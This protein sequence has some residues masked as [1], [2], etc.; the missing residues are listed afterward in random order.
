MVMEFFILLNHGG[1]LFT[2]GLLYS[3]FE[4]EFGKSKFETSV[5]SALYSSSVFIFAP[6][7][8][9]LCRRF[10]HRKTMISG[11]IISAVALFVSA[12][13]PSLYMLY[14]TAGLV[15]GCGMSMLVV[16][17]PVVVGYYFTKWRQVA[18]GILF[19]G[20]G[21]GLIVYT[22]TITYILD[23]YGWR[24]TLIISSGL[25]LNGAVFA[26]FFRPLPIEEE[27][28]K[29][30]N[31]IDIAIFK[32]VPF[33]VLLLTILFSFFAMSIPWIIVPV[34]AK[35][36]EMTGTEILIILTA[37]GICGILGRVVFTLFGLLKNFN[38]NLGMSIITL[39]NGVPILIMVYSC[40]FWA[41]AVLSS[42]LGFCNGYTFPA[43]SI[44]TVDLVGVQKFNSAWGLVVC[45]MGIA[46]LI[47]PPLAG[48]IYDN[49]ENYF[50]AALLT[51]IV[52]TLAAS[53]Y[54][55]LDVYERRFKKK[56]S[57]EKQLERLD[58]TD[59]IGSKIYKSTFS[60]GSSVF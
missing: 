7:T 33:L 13:A 56:E 46:W 42:I 50:G 5:V 57:T 3:Y 21:V 35:N 2:P 6:F 8:S 37:V 25:V 54:I 10:G 15:A 32:D 53:F 31:A 52:S 36:C 39:I 48:L 49:T 40:N 24:G 38:H 27:L 9:M 20:S 43:S 47:G 28:R 4:K 18:T 1:L 34:Q 23:Y 26:A 16:A 14:A 29:K 45:C 22:Y 59:Y 55:G 17:S 58:E 19:L 41:I 51:T 60:Y 44:V 12:F 11:A 30:S